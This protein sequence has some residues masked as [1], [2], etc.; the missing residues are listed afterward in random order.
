MPKRLNLSH[1]ASG[2]SFLALFGVSTF[3]HL[4]ITIL[5]AAVFLGVSVMSAIHHAEVIAE[6]VGPSLGALILAL[7]VTVIEVGLILSMM[8]HATSNAAVVARDTVFSAVII[9]ANGITGFCFLLG[10][11]RYREL[12]FRLEGTS[13]LLAVLATLV[14]VALILPNYTTS[15]PGPSYSNVQLIF[16][17]VACLFLYFALFIS[18]TITHKDYFSV[19][20]TSPPQEHSARPSRTDTWLSAVALVLSL[21]AVIGLAKSLSP[22]IEQGVDYLGAPRTAVGIVIALLVLLPE[23]GAALAA[24]RANQLQTSLNLAL[25]SGVASVALTIPAIAIYSIMTQQKVSL[26]LEPKSIAFT[27]LTFLVSGL[28]L[29]TGKISALKGSVHLAIVFSYIVLSFIP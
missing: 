27:V 12:E 18:Q 26:G 24:A 21:I 17:S 23:A 20:E 11:I 7:A 3:S 19:E 6:R 16:A 10:G 1:L 15:T 9:V 8:A 29:S 5:V 22:S 13:S 25:G 4:G 2:V 28:T 14:G